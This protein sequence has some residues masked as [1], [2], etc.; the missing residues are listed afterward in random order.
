MMKNVVML[1][2]K[3]C[4]LGKGYSHFTLKTSDIA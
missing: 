1:I 4:F 3:Y 2:L